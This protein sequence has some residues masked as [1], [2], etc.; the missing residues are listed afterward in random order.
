MAQPSTLGRLGIRSLELVEDC[1]KLS[2]AEAAMVGEP[3]LEVF[4][5]IYAQAHSK[6]LDRYLIKTS[7]VPTSLPSELMLWSS[8]PPA[9]ATFVS[10]LLSVIYVP[11]DLTTDYTLIIVS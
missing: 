5:I 4:W 11:Y 3:S 7:S 1:L 6:H 10:C 9:K 8:K 2:Q